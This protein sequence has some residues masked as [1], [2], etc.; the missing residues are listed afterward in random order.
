MLY[1]LTT[2]R[3]NDTRLTVLSKV[4]DEYDYTD[5]N[6]PA[7]YDDIAEFEERNQICIYVH[8]WIEDNKPIQ[9]KAGNTTYIL[10]ECIYLL[11]IEN[12]EQSHYVYVKNI[13]SFLSLHHH[14]EDH[15]KLVCPICQGSINLTNCE[16][17]VPRATSM[18]N[19]EHSWIFP[20]PGEALRNSR[21]IWT[22]HKDHSL[23]MATWNA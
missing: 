18:L 21:I 2:K 23:F 9:D 12:E 7:S 13:G 15:G 6:Y 3:Q 17:T 19:M 14:K 11:R 4:A 20:N 5:I 10:N 8:R 22:S 16:P 1:D